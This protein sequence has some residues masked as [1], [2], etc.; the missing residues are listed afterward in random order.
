MIPAETLEELTCLRNRVEDLEA[1]LAEIKARREDAVSALHRAFGLPFGEARL[2]SVLAEGGIQN[3]DRLLAACDNSDGNIRLADSM[4]K[5]IR[6]RLPW[7]K[8]LT[9]YNFGYELDGESLAAV[10]AAIRRGNT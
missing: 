10:R 7:L 2:L 3:R 4:V 8:I 1:E 6:R 5:R 9:H